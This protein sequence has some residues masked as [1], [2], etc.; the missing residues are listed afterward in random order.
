MFQVDHH[1][2]EDKKD[3]RNGNQQNKQYHH[4]ILTPL[5]RKDVER[6]A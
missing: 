5:L 6:C 3:Y 2:E 1:I 4:E